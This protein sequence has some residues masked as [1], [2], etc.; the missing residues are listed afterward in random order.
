MVQD[1][2]VDQLL[3]SFVG[4]TELYSGTG[5]SFPFDESIIFRMILEIF[6]RIQSHIVIV[7]AVAPVPGGKEAVVGNIVVEVPPAAD[8]VFNGRD[9]LEG[10]VFR[11]GKAFDFRDAIAEIWGTGKDCTGEAL[12]KGQHCFVGA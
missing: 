6:G 3:H 1:L 4:K 12:R 2:F 8:S 5:I 10:V 11:N 7:S 9:T